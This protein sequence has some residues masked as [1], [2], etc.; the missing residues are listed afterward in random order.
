MP[1]LEDYMRAFNTLNRAPRPNSPLTLD[2]Q[3]HKPIFLLSV[4]DMIAAGSYPDNSIHLCPELNDLFAS[5][6]SLAL[7]NEKVGDITMPFTH[8]QKRRGGFWHLTGER[9]PLTRTRIA[10]FDEELFTLATDSVSRVVLQAILIES[11]FDE[12]IRPAL[13]ELTRT[14]VDALSY[15]TAILKKLDIVKDAP[16]AVRS[17]AFRMIVVKAY[18]YRCA[19]CGIRIFNREGRT[20][21]EA[22]HIQPWSIS[23]DDA[24]DNGLSLCRLCHWSFDAGIL[25][26]AADYTVL[27][28]PR[29]LIANNLGG[30]LITTAS[31]PIILPADEAFYPST[32]KLKWHREWH[33]EKRSVM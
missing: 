18:E 13:R 17:Q 7:P 31:Q 33:R 11:H 24:P 19:I 9:H 29:L 16:P 28:S 12:A 3:P 27:T 30:H 4:L 6:W 23:H 5:Y 14:T 25:A 32:V 26:V 22:A 21:V 10:R 15:G 1:T 8:L 2:K 20:A